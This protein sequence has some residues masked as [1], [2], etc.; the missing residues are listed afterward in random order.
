VARE[1]ELPTVRRIAYRIGVHVGDIVADDGDIYGNGVN[2]AARLEALAEP[3]GVYLSQQAYDQVEARDDIRCSFV[4]EQAMKNLARPIRVYRVAIDVLAAEAPNSPPIVSRATSPAI[5][6]ARDV[7]FCSS[8]DSTMIGYEV[9]GAGPAVIRAATWMS[10]LDHDWSAPHRAAFYTELTREH[11]L[12]R[13]DQRGN[14]LSDRDCADLSLEAQ[15]SDIEAVANAADLE[16][17]A[18]YGGSQGGAVAAAYAARHPERVTHLVLHGAYAQG[19]RA[20]GNVD[21]IKRREAMQSLIEVGWGTDNSAFHQVFASLFIPGASDAQV[22]AWIEL[23]R[24]SVMPKTAA[25]LHDANGRFDIVGLLP[26]IRVPTLVTHSRHDAVQPF[27]VGRKMAS[28]I[29]GARFV[30]LESHNHV[31]LPQEP[32]WP[33]FIGEIIEFLRQPSPRPA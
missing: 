18:L 12:V 21:E 29:P 13:Y 3:N 7:R 8:A 15:V 19:W 16:R 28:L 2:V 24:A 4:G 25:A 5:E 22:K 10:H 14:G 23:Q 11:R 6:A 27:E 30:A 33:R 26:K 20:R 17:F 1:R 32:A 31:I 9:T